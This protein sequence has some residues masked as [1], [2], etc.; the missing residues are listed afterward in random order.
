[1]IA[2]AKRHTE[3]SGLS[4]L[5]GKPIDKPHTVDPSR[6]EIG[7]RVD[8]R[9]PRASDMARANDDDN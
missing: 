9:K 2:R 1:M 5:L 7:A 6:L 4:A 3:A 8:K